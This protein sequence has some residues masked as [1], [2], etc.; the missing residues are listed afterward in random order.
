MLHLADRW[1]FLPNIE[2]IRLHVS[3]VFM[4]MRKAFY[5]TIGYYWQCTVRILVV[6]LPVINRTLLVQFCQHHGTCIKHISWR[7]FG[8]LKSFS[9]SV[10]HCA[11]TGSKQLCAKNNGY[12]MNCL[13]T[14]QVPWCVRQKWLIVLRLRQTDLDAYLAGFWCWHYLFIWSN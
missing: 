3:F 14:S 5:C 12:P 6:Y 13:R 11:L 8:F 9:M 2:T 10:F 7:Q 4:K 1:S